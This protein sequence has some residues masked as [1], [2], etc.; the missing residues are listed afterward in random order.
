MPVIA[1][2]VVLAVIATYAVRGFMRG[3]TASLL[4]LLGVVVSFFAAWLCW[5]WAGRFLNASFNLPPVLACAIGAALVFLV[6]NILFSGLVFLI[7]RRNKA[8]RAQTAANPR[9][10][11]AD[12]LSG[13]ALGACFGIL[14]AAML[15]WL[16]NV[17]GLTEVGA[18]WPDI[19]NSAAGRLS[20]FIIRS[21]A[22]VFTRAATNS[23]ALAG[24]IARSARDPKSAAEDIE[25]I[26][27]N[28]EVTALIQDAQF[29]NAVLRADREAI[30][31]NPRLNRLLEDR[32]FVRSAR[33]LGFLPA[34]SE[35]VSTQDQ[36]AE[37]LA[38]VG[39]KMARIKADPEVQDVMRDAAI[40]K[41]LDEKNFDG[42]VLDERVWKLAG[43]VMQIIRS[44]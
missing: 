19:R 16:Y 17:A 44:D 28:R 22:Y 13:A 26:K 21:E 30:K 29:T 7:R 25:R 38:R 42:L 9:Y 15:V 40:Q 4:G 31:R 23:P 5:G 6:V 32:A 2:L 43:R 37:Y 3:L 36:A 11:W 34:E 1:D 18:S 41:M 14:M 24:I 35:T 27:Q 12:K 33:N 39:L 8:K 20:G 10:P